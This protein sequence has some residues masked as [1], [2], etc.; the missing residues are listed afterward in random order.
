MAEGEVE[1]AGALVHI[2]KSEGVNPFWISKV[3]SM[4]AS[5]E[6]QPPSKRTISSQKLFIRYQ[7]R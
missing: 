3:Q 7:D 5:L 4:M 1:I 2:L 6:V